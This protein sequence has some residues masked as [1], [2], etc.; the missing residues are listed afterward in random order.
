E[1][2]RERLWVGTQDGGVGFYERGRFR[3]LPVCGDTC[4]VNRIF[5]LDG[6][7]VWMLAT[8]G[9]FRVDVDTLETAAY[10]QAFDAYLVYAIAGGEAF[11]AGRAGLAR[12][13]PGGLHPIALPD[14]HAA[15]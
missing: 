5:S 10:V 13:A 11:V 12:L 4:L 14:G 8:S 1:D 6:R 15:V 3:P 7:T 9:I 2:A